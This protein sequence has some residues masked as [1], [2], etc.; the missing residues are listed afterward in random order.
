MHKMAYLKISEVSEILNVH[1]NKEKSLETKVTT[2]PNKI[3]Q[4]LEEVAVDNLQASDVYQS[5]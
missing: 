1:F 4:Y 5:Q 2:Q 3:L